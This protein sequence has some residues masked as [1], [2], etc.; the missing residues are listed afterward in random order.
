MYDRIRHDILSGELPPGSSLVETALADRYGMSRTPIREALLQLR[1]DGLVERNGR[2]LA[3][4]Q[5]SPEEIL[6]IYEVRVPLEE[7]AARLAATRRTDLDLLRLTR[8][9]RDMLEMTG[10]E[11]ALRT[12]ANRAFHRQV[13]LASHNHTL[14]DMLERIGEQLHRNPES[15]L[16]H[17]GRWDQVLKDHEELLEAISEQLPDKSKEIWSRHMVAGRSIRLQMY[18]S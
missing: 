12:T 17:P 11:R 5:Q 7:L 8:A 10:D 3:V 9:H 13:W 2:G 16:H 1:Q 4:R 18:S 15:P 6:E 14:I